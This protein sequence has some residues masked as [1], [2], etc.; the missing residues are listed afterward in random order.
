MEPPRSP[1]AA[2]GFVSVGW[3]RGGRESC[4]VGL[5]PEGGCMSVRPTITPAAL[6]FIVASKARWPSDEY[7][8]FKP[9]QI[10]AIT[11][12]WGEHAWGNATD[13]LAYGWRGRRRLRKDVEWSLQ[14]AEYF[15]IDVILHDGFVWR[16]DNDFVA[17]PLRPQDNPHTNSVHHSFLPRSEG[18]PPGCGDG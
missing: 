2:C 17:E 9:C 8:C 4:S 11:G 6:R 1:P 12:E 13:H 18:T 14:M 16:R 3:W 10:S 15:N 5:S 7:R